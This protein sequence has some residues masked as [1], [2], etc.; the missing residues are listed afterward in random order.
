MLRAVAGDQRVQCAGQSRRHQRY[1]GCGR[2]TTS[3]RADAPHRPLA[4]RV[5]KPRGWGRWNQAGHA[6]RQC[7][8]VRSLRGLQKIS[9]NETSGAKCVRTCVVTQT[10]R[11]GLFRAGPVLVLCRRRPVRTSSRCCFPGPRGLMYR[12]SSQAT[13]PMPTAREN[14]PCMCRLAKPLP[15]RSQSSSFCME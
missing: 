14:L 11:I 10:V 7:D 1:R 15:P 12:V 6:Q 4:S 8:V 5:G 2:D 9:W 13:R 3:H